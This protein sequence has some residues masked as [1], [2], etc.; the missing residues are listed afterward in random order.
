VICATVFPE[1]ANVLFASSIGGTPRAHP[2][3]IRKTWDRGMPLSRWTRTVVM[4][5]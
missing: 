5:L 3:V 1:C 2:P 4:P